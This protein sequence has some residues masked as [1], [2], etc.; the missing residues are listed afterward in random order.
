MR[1]LFRMVGPIQPSVFSLFPAHKGHTTKANH[2]IT[3]KQKKNN[4]E[5]DELLVRRHTDEAK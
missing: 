2:R 4:R 3:N 5:G 1:F